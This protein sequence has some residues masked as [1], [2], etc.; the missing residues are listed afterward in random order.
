MMQKVYRWFVNH[1]PELESASTK[2]SSPTAVKT[3]PKAKTAKQLFADAHASEV[4]ARMNELSKASNSPS[5]A[6]S[7]PYYHAA[8]DAL[9][10]ELDPD[11]R[12]RFEGDAAAEKAK[13]DAPPPRAEIYA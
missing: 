2:T 8:L 7:L 12:K 11:E 9:W 13:Y 1:R 5:A 3:K 6:G 10:K 4:H